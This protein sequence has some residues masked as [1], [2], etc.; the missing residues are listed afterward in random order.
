MLSAIFGYKLST[1]LRV[2]VLKFSEPLKGGAVNFGLRNRF[3]ITH[4]RLVIH[5]GLNAYKLPVASM[6]K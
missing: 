2:V 5:F 3:K 6:E 4:S 1:V